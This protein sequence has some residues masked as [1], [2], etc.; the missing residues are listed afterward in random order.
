MSGT[1]VV[2]CHRL[3][4]MSLFIIHSSLWHYGICGIELTVAPQVILAY[5]LYSVGRLTAGMKGV[6]QVLAVRRQ[7]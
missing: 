1:A 7:R 2:I 4:V 5:T 6:C 3:S